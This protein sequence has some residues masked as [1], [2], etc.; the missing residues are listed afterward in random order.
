M[1]NVSVRY[2]FVVAGILLAANSAQAQERR[3]EISPYV[4]V[5]QVL[6][7]DLSGTDAFGPG[8]DVVTY[9]SVAAGL[10][11][12]IAT[13][14]VELSS[15][16]RY[17]R[18]IDW[19]NDISD[20]DVHSG[21]ARGR[22]NVAR[23]LSLEAGALAARARQ[24][25]GGNDLGF[26]TGDNDNATQI[27][28]VYGG[29]T[30]STQAGPL[31]IGAGAQIGYTHVEDSA[32]ANSDPNE[33][34]VDYIDNSTYY[35]ATASV[36]MSPGTS[37]LP[38]GWIVSGAY[39]RED[40]EQLDQRYESY[41]ARVDVTVPVSPELALIGGVGYENIEI[42][43]RDVLVDGNG[44]P[45]LDN[46]G[47]FVAD[48]ASPRL[49]AFDTEGFIYD[50]GI[51]W[52]PSPRLEVSA[53]VGERYDTTFYQGSVSYQASEYA[54]LQFNVYNTIESFGRN[55]TSTLS[56]LT[57]DFTANRNGFGQFGGCA[58]GNG[59]SGGAC[60]DSD[61]ASLNSANFR[62]RGASLV[63]SG[64]RGPWSYGVGGAYENRRYFA[65]DT[66]ANFSLNRVTDE[67]FAIQANAGYQLSQNSSLDGT[68]YANWFESGIP[69]ETDVFS[70]GGAAT[71]N[72]NLYRGLSA[73][74]SAGVFV[75]DFDDGS[76][77]DW[78]GTLLFGMRYGF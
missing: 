35:Q 39:D 51:L 34:A 52:R 2:S 1:L 68:V 66:A 64:G 40:A 4:E 45:V 54:G 46:N 25:I 44:E 65:P 55:T 14:R 57:T 76:E 15:S 6:D 43:Q 36:G 73:L 78:L 71:Y 37:E 9:T 62:A 50:A 26:E 23:G 8:E 38:F 75:N 29:P 53:R 67:V 7:F 56:G 74:A 47:R 27:Y 70:S 49:L 16:Y 3:V 33:S 13:R 59:N 48:P 63:W 30:V 22:V 61:F 42:S 19:S 17:E 12:S 58:F 24:S 21:V 32:S 69:G 31:E 41:Q 60:F 5:Q 28:S 11:A 10:D 18:R 77:A 72:V 20:E